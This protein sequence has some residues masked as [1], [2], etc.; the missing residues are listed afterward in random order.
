MVLA[1][2]LPA[3][4]QKTIDYRTR[5][6]ELKRGKWAGLDVRLFKPR[7]R[8]GYFYRSTA[9]KSK[10]VLHYTMGFLGGDLS[11]LTR[12]DVHVS[13]PFVISRGGLVFQL[14]DPKFW[15]YHLGPGAVGG[16]EYNS[17]RSI[18]IEFSNIGPLERSG[19]WL[20]NYYGSRYCRVGETEFY[21][22]LGSNYR[23][24][25]YYAT[26]TQ[27]QYEAGDRLIRKIA[28]EFQIPHRF[29][30][31][32]ARYDLF[33]KSKTARDYTGICSHVN[34]RPPAEKT[35]IGPGFDWAAIG[36]GS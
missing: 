19:N 31:T 4:E 25:R 16:N 26:F 12:D 23:D 30:P 33:E 8:D 6:E 3:E 7:N 11:Q 35:D 9:K 5:R 18:G 36:A 20:W 28:S 32:D 17:R 29:L 1:V 15:S 13:V 24:Y 34:F 22:D 14:F 2:D 10:V 21:T 27:A